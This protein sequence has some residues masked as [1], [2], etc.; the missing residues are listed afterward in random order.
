M[1]PSLILLMYPS[2]LITLQ[3]KLNCHHQK[4]RENTD[5]S[6]HGAKI[7]D[8]TTMEDG[9]AA[10]PVHAKVDYHVA[11]I[12]MGC[13]DNK[14]FL[15]TENENVAVVGKDVYISYPIFI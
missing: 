10:P 9:S 5:K 3:N 7:C 13:H 15:Q 12:E 14:S 6:D 11:V 8:V 4:N 2:N 1:S